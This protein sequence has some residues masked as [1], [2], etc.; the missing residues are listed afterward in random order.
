MNWFHFVRMLAL[1]GWVTAVSS[2]VAIGAVPVEIAVWDFN[3][4]VQTNSPAPSVGEG[5]AVAVGGVQLTIA[6]GSGSSDP[7]TSGDGAWGLAGFPAQGSGDRSSGVEFRVG[8]VG[9]SN[10]VVR[11]DVRPSNTASRVL[12]AQCSVDGTEFFDV[13]RWVLT[14][15]GVFTNRLELDLSTIAGVADNARFAFRLV[16]A[17]DDGGRYE[18][19]TG[20]YSVA[21][22]WRL[23]RVMVVG[24]RAGSG[25]TGGGEGEGEGEGGEGG[26]TE[27]PSLRY[28]CRWT[29]GSGVGGTS[30]N[31]F[32]DQALGPGERLEI[33]VTVSGAG[34]EGYRVVV[35]SPEG[36]PEGSGWGE[37]GEV[38]DAVGEEVVVFRLAVEESLLG[39]RF[40]P[41]LSVSN[42]AGGLRQVWRI[43]VPTAAQR[44]VVLTE[45]FANPPA[46]PT[47]AAFNP[48]R[49]D[50]VSARP[51]QQDEYLEL[52]NFG[53]EA[54]GLGGWRLRDA[55][56][57]RYAFPEATL[58]GS[59]EALVLH[60]ALPG[61]VAPGLGV[62]VGTL[63]AGEG[64][65]GLSLNN[66]G[67]VIALYDESTNLVFR[68]VYTAD[69]LSSGGSLTRWPEAGGEFVAHSAVSAQ[70]VSP[71]RRYDGRSYT[72]PG[73]TGGGGGEVGEPIRVGVGAEREGEAIHL[74]W[75]VTAGRAYRVWVAEE[76][77][78]PYHVLA[79][80]LRFATGEGWYRVTTSGLGERGFF[81]ISED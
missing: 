63:A 68:V 61:S 77:A 58:L 40:E 27:A 29:G 73:E 28:V 11:F 46:N 17:W 21:G 80:G 35:E 48:L 44:G 5:T 31:A 81:R 16:S 13:R 23:D 9:Y 69:M 7:V 10:V 38:G 37:T 19:V 45:F 78:G 43:S 42:R 14:A 18:A 34:S 41:A 25:G 47:N 76:L 39:R 74:S 55:T 60:G 59:G 15:G 72:E 51:T 64:V 1:V 67:D 56:G 49:R 54:V 66:D 52:V 75:K 32:S 12:Q 62:G 71:G 4:V 65:V 33:E 50:P 2:R 3:G 36:L 30:T 53:E 6:A 24:E 26:V 20:N 79:E 57:W 8:T 70:P 22:T